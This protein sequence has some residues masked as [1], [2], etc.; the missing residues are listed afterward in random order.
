MLG[1]RARNQI[2]GVMYNKSVI[3]SVDAPKTLE[4]L[5]KD[6]PQTEAAAAAKERLSRLK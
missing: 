6:F 4:D 3:K 2:V 5:V 1:P